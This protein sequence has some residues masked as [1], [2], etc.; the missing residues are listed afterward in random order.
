M[1]RSFFAFVA[2]V[3]VALA[4][5]LCQTSSG[6]AQPEKIT[7]AIVIHGGAGGKGATTP[8]DQPLSAREQLIAD[9]VKI[10]SDVLSTGGSALDACEKVVRAFE[11]SGKFNTGKGATSTGKG[12]YSLDA[13]IMD[14]SNVGFGAIAGVKTIKNP[15]SAARAVMGTKDHVLLM[16]SGAEEF[17]KD[18]GMDIVLP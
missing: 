9:Y 4:P 16:G 14:G 3:V 1:S 10:G 5:A 7:W 6:A 17:A 8:A 11:D 13:A 15:I 18:K 12:T 2:A